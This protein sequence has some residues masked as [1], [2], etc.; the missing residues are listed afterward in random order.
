L[1]GFCLTTPHEMAVILE[2]FEE[3]LSQL[4]IARGSDRA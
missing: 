1:R 3:V 2:A 4:G